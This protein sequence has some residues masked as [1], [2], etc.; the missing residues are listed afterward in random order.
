MT[1]SEKRF[2]QGVVMSINGRFESGAAPVA[3]AELERLTETSSPCFV[4]DCSAMHYVSSA[5]LQAILQIAKKVKSRHKAQVAAVG[6]DPL[7]HEIFKVSGVSAM[8]VFYPTLAEIPLG[9]LVH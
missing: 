6:L 3:L 9:D 2:S 8:L 1:I 4:F 5:G 7:V